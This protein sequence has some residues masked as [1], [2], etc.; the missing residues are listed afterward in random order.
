MSSFVKSRNGCQQELS[1]VSTQFKDCIDLVKKAKSKLQ[2]LQHDLD[3]TNAHLIE[4]KTAPDN[5]KW[6]S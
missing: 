3:V 4:L 2:V 5:D 1:L 6:D